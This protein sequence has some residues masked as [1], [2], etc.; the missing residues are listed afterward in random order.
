MGMKY[1]SDSEKFYENQCG[2]KKIDC[3]IC[4]I[5]I[6]R[7]EIK[8][9]S[10]NVLLIHIRTANSATVTLN[11]LYVDVGARIMYKVNT[12]RMGECK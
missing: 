12:S 4:N 7:V 11:C 3:E 8:R 10:K 2:R 5:H 6:K 9:E 1:C